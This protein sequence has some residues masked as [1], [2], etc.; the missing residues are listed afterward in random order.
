MFERLDDYFQL[1]FELPHAQIDLHKDVGS[2]SRR[3]GVPQ[4]T[5]TP[6]GCQRRRL[7]AVSVAEER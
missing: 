6:S 2:Y 3:E 7:S 4:E 1:D 5:E